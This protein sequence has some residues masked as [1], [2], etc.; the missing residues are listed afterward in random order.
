MFFLDG[1]SGGNNFLPLITPQSVLLT[2]RGRVVLSLSRP[3]PVAAHFGSYLAPEYQHGRKYQDQEIEK[4]K[5]EKRKK[6]D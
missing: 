6:K 4:V 5:K 1:V 2:G 3:R